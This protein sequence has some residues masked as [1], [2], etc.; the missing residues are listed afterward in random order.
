MLRVRVGQTVGVGG[1]GVVGRASDAERWED[2]GMFGDRGYGVANRVI[3]L[4]KGTMDG[5]H[6][7]CL[8]VSMLERVVRV[9]GRWWSIVVDGEDTEV[10]VIAAFTRMSFSSIL[11]PG[12]C[13]GK[14]AH[15]GG[16]GSRS[17]LLP[18][19]SICTQRSVR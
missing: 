16:Y 7:V 1:T 4:C 5:V 15:G 14:T 6:V 11:D 19:H 2:S 8:L 18:S 17:P 10:T 13:R 9:G 3:R 12:L